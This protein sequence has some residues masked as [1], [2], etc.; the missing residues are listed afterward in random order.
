MEQKT[1]KWL[2]W[3]KQGIGA[4]DAPII[5]GVSPYKTRYELWLEKTGQREDEQPTWAMQR[6]IDMEAKARAHYELKYNADM[7]PAVVEHQQHPY[8]RASLDGFNGKTVLEIKCPGKEDHALALNGIVPPKYYPQLQHQLMVTG[9]GCAHYWSFDGEKGVLL[10]VLPDLPYI[11]KLADIEMGFWK[12]VLERRPP[13]LTDR[14]FKEVEDKALQLDFLKWGDIEATIKSLEKEQDKI[15]ERI[16][17]KADH[18]KLQ[19]GNVQLIKYS[20]KG[21][22]DYSKVPGL[23]NSLEE[24]RAPTKE[25]FTLKLVK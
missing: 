16:M 21:N 1:D 3:R 5:M 17:D 23:P 4:S 25:I 10:E 12:N 22:I 6:G 9:A 13:E 15:R 14:D 18:P 2:E 11:V 24:F 20:R 19:Y 8:L 7:P